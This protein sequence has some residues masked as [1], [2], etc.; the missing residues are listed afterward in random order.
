MKYRYLT[1]LGII[2]CGIGFLPLLY[3]VEIDLPHRFLGIGK[4]LSFSGYFSPYA[5]FGIIAFVLGISFVLASMLSEVCR[6][7]TH[8][9]KKI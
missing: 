2:F 4:W 9:T 6:N 1:L 7:N 8:A 3:V 5:I